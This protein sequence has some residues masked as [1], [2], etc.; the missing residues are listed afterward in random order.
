MHPFLTV[1]AHKYVGLADLKDRRTALLTSCRQWNL[2]GSILLSPEGISVVV[3]G[4]ADATQRLIETLRNWSGLEDLR[5]RVTGTDRQSFV[6]MIVRVKREIAALGIDGLEPARDPAPGISPRDLRLWLDEN[7]P[8][9]LLDVRNSYESRD[10]TFLTAVRT[11]IEHFHEL[12]QRLVELR[13]RLAGRPVITFCTTGIRSEK[14]AALLRREGVERVL[15]LDGGILNYFEHCGGTHYE[16]D[17]FLFEQRGGIEP[18]SPQ[19]HWS[20]CLQCKHP[21][22]LEDQRHKHFEAGTACPYCH[23]ISADDMAGQITCRHE[24]I[25]CLIHP[26]PGSVPQDHFRPITIPAICDGLTLLEALGRVVAHIPTN[27]WRERC[28]NGLLLDPSGRAAHESSVVRAGERYL[29]R[30]PAITEPDVNMRVELLHEDEALLV[31][32]KPAPLPMHAGGRFQRNT[33]K[34]ILDALY[35]PQSPKPAHRLDANTT[36]VLVVAR[37]R[38][39]AGKIQAQFARGEVEKTYLTRVHGHPLTDDFYCAAPISADAGHAGSRIIDDVSGLRARTEFRVLCRLE[40]G[41]ALLEAR[42]LT[43][44]TNQIRVH[45]WHLGFPICGDPVYLRDDELGDSQ[46]LPID[47][48]PLCLHAWRIRFQHP[49][50]RERCEFIAPPPKWFAD[51]QS[52]DRSCVISAPST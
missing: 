31:L 42:P 44:R 14:A 36:G 7:R 30:F 22:T 27:F 17:C 39:F 35:E 29:H 9:T 49:L 37:T 23:E 25:K 52:Q 41:T 3:S 19:G 47:A 34:Y 32:N 20:E 2:R 6:R 11:D 12:P 33:L 45:L 5:P 46:T 18:A 51:T 48:A 4:E 38:H 1:T 26:L 15:S 16:G 50:W 24:Q 21:L 8:I 13:P 10:G 40:D 28:A 43:G